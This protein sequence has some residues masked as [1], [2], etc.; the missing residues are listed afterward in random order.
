MIPGA[1]ILGLAR[2]VIGF[3]TAKHYKNR[4][5][6]DGADGIN[7]PSY[8][9]GNDISVS[10]QPLSRTMYE[11]LGL[12]LQKSYVTIYSDVRLQDVQR[13]KAPDMVD[14]GGDRY[15]VE[16]NTDWVNQDGW[17][18]ALCVRQGPITT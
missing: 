18:G 8:Y 3:Q 4:G 2:Q 12:D 16:S 13:D 15:V 10:V 11:Q 7:S 9:P 6:V 14:Y 17:L 1:N 5:T